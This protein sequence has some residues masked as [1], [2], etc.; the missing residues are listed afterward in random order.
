[1]TRSGQRLVT[2][3]EDGAAQKSLLEISRKVSATIG[4]DFFHAIAKHL[5]EALAADC[6]AVMEFAGGQMERC[7]SVGAW[8]SGAPASFEYELA[9]SAAA[10]IVQ[11]RPC[12]W[13]SHVRERFPSDAFLSRSRAEA[14]VGVPLPT[15]GSP[16]I[17]ALMAVYHQPV[18]GLRFPKAMLQTFAERAAAELTRKLEEDKLRESEQR[19]RAFIA[20]NPDAMW[21]VEFEQPILTSLP[22]EEQ[23]D[24]IHQYGYLAECNDA[25]ARLLGRE[26]ADQLIGARVDEVAPARDPSARHAT[27]VAIHAGYRLTTVETTPIDAAG[28]RRC[29]LRSQWGIVEDGRLVRIW[30]ANRDITELRHAEMALDASEQRM[31]DLIE[32]ARMLVAFVNLNGTIEFCNS[33]MH[34]ITGWPAEELFGKEWVGTLIPAAER[35]RVM[36]ELKRNTPDFPVHFESSLVTRDGFLQVEWDSTVLKNS[37]G[38]AAVRA[39]VGRDMTEQ[40][41]LQE[42]ILQAQKLAGIG[43]LAGGLAHDF[44]NLL[45]VIL[46]YTSKLLDETNPLD[47]SMA[48]LKQIE[49]AAGKSAE[50]AHRLLTFSR[51]EV[52]RPQV[53]DVNALVEDARSLLEA[54]AGEDVRLVLNLQPGLRAVRADPTQFHQIL[55]NLGAN[56]RDA[57]PQGGVLTFATSN[58]DIAPHEPHPAGV[59][60]GEYVLLTIADSGTGMTEEVKSHLF[61]P[62][63]TTKEAGR[64]TG[65]GLAVVYGI[66]QQSA[67][68]IR[69]DSEPGRGTTFRIFL[70]R[71][72]AVDVPEQPPSKDELPRGTETV[73][74]VGNG[75]SL[76]GAATKLGDLGYT[77]LSADDP[78]QALEISRKSASPIQLMITVAVTHGMPGEVLLKMVKEFQ[79]NI[80]VL[81]VSDGKETSASGDDPA[82]GFDFLPKPFS[83][84]RLALKVREILDRG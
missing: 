54:L 55:M 25:V 10:Q 34:E 16:P 60:A 2:E 61:E 40:K 68:Q 27:M 23:F 82:P 22:A 48:S 24:R 64:G 62:F 50:L 13:R 7:R 53:M 35:G 59:P 47:P 9:G 84:K 4:T 30:G 65:L 11:G 76:P 46:G 75:R 39:L 69:V 21:R 33:Y 56:A 71:A 74:L 8:C 57:M 37:G 15:D 6:V 58:F 43:R 1:M 38:G 32:S 49:K 28:N 20:K 66:V 63:F 41:A 45:T 51:R 14:C 67:G 52:F 19:Y 81:L 77:I 26:S 18:P 5:A 80:K 79:P 17:G 70:P 12:H 78:T 83:R 31:A 73:L 36:D 29:M 72:N 42:Q 44:N 3:N